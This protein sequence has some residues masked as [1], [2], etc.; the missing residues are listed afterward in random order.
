MKNL[1]LLLGA[2]LILTVL[3]VQAK[4]GQSDLNLKLWNNTSFKVILNNESFGK[5]NSFY[6][7]NLKPG[8]HD[9]K[10]LKVKRNRHGN[11]GFNKLMYQGQIRIPRNARVSATITP[12]K[13]I[14]VRVVKKKNHHQNQYSGYGNGGYGSNYDSY[15]SDNF[16]NQYG[17]NVT[18]DAGNGYEA[19]NYSISNIRLNQLTVVMDDA[20]FDRAKLKIAKQALYQNYFRTDQVILLMS[21]F[22]FES[23]RLKFAKLAYEKTIDKENYFLVNREF[24]FNS[25]INNLNNYI[26]RY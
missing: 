3:N 19:Y 7:D 5:T 16:Y 17:S 13:R 8:L 10:V 25:S 18:C 22:A 14:K 2:L 24:S 21:Q 26:N 20:H 23:N 11:G 6:L 12:D 4:Y 15:E 9:I 1:R